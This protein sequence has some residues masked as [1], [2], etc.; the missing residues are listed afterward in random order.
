MIVTPV[1]LKLLPH[2]LDEWLFSPVWVVICIVRLPLWLK[3]SPQWLHEWFFTPVCFFHVSYQMTPVAKMLTT[4]ITRIIFHFFLL[5]CGFLLF[6]DY[7]PGW[8][9]NY[10]DC[11][12][13]FYSC[14]G[15][16]MCYQ[17]TLMRETLT[18]L[19][20]SIFFSF[21]Y[22]CGLSYVF[23][24]YSSGWNSYHTDYMN[25]ILLLCGLSYVFTD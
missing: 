16:N 10:T 14:V 15:C 9:S 1:W 11:M 2:W 23:S 21:F 4:L 13:D 3:L 17:T 25:D 8:N 5:L 6:S 12:N 22:S 19:I 24:D 18:T 20:T 7:S